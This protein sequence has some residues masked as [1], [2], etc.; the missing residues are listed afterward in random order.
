[1]HPPP[2]PAVTSGVAPTE[3]GDEKAKQ[4][5]YPS[6]FLR[7]VSCAQVPMRWRVVFTLSVYLAV[8]AAEL[9]AL[10]WDDI[11]LSRGIVHVHRSVR[12]YA[13]TE[14]TTKTGAKPRFAIEQTLLPV[15]RAL[16][17]S[18]GGRGRVL[19]AL[20]MPNKLELSKALRDYLALAQIT[21]AELFVNDA[22]RKWMTF[23]DLRATGLTWMAVRGDDPLRIK[24]RAG[25]K[26]PTRPRSGTSARRRSSAT[27]SA[28]CSRSCRGASSRHSSRQ[29]LRSEDEI[30]RSRVEIPPLGPRWDAQ[31]DERRRGTALTQ[32]S[33]PAPGGTRI[34][35]ACS[36]K[37]H[38]RRGRGVRVQ[39]QT[40]TRLRVIYVDDNPA[41]RRAVVR[42]LRTHF[43]IDDVGDAP[44]VEAAILVT[45]YD[46]FITDLEMP[47]VDGYEMIRRVG[48][49]DARLARRAVILSGGYFTEDERIDLATKGYL[50]VPKSASIQ[51]IVNAVLL[52]IQ[53]HP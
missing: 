53:Q 41:V 18:T 49:L 14:K 1:M 12:R 16:H 33:A 4:Y 34:A 17:R 40:P 20:G 31:R 46:G 47:D 6:E 21:R 28:R 48:A 3:Y 36:R 42:M 24:H 35:G 5:L 23:H 25:H 52:R 44:S 10:G 22:T 50:I 45:R 8:R 32:L 7:L 39:V 29:S 11:D 27:G 19:G 2:D 9:E 37:P 30:G 13:R 26:T 43:G 51:E 38:A 15:L